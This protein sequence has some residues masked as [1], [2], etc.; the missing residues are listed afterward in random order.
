MSHCYDALFIGYQKDKI[1]VD[2]EK[3]NKNLLDIK[4]IKRFFNEKDN[5]RIQNISKELLQD[6]VI[7]N[8]GYKRI[9]YK[10]AKWQS[11]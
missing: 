4:I 7:A 1:G 11:F 6:E 8:M 2:I 5:L 10:M 3:F 9:S